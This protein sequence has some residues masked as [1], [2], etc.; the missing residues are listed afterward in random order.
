MKSKTKKIILA[1]VISLLSAGLITTIPFM[2]YFT[3]MKDYACNYTD[4]GTYTP[5]PES[6]TAKASKEGQ[7]V[8]LTYTTSTYY[9]EDVGLIDSAKGTKKTYVSTTAEE[10]KAREDVTVEKTI[11]V[12]LPYGYDQTDTT[13]KYNIM[14]FMHGGGC[15][16]DVLVKGAGK[17]SETKRVL[18]NMIEKGDIEPTIFVF[19]EWLYHF[20]TDRKDTFCMI[21]H[22]LYEFKKDVLP[23]V[24]STYN[25]YSNITKDMTEEQISESLKNTRE[26]RAVGGYSCGSCM[27]WFIFEKYLDYFKWYMPTSGD[28]RLNLDTAWNQ[29]N[30]VIDETYETEISQLSDVVR[31][32]GWTS[33]DYFINFNVGGLDFAY[34][35][36]QSQV[37]AM[38]Q[39]P[40]I[41][42]LGTDSTDGNFATCMA[43]GVW[44]T[45]TNSKYF[46][47]NALPKFFK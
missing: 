3:V 20:D 4:D 18:D 19:P 8:G 37:R 7:I 32:S 5:L 30:E 24:E 45:D 36:V 17:D 33:K 16:N 29:T 14:Y 11:L 1:S 26:H 10:I 21:G 12:Y 41:F 46:F 40:D 6:Y 9:K 31:K 44:H 47:Y 23:L 42:Q 25:V 43:P 39:H 22:Y 2:C 28:Y 38:I 13:K 34:P 35:A 27:T 15:Y